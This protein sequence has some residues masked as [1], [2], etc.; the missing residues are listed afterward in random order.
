MDEKILIE[1]AKK[2]DKKAFEALIIPYERRLFQSAL[3]LM[4]NK[5][6]AE[7]VTQET[8]LIIYKKLYQFRGESKFYTWASRILINMCNKFRWKRKR[9]FD[10]YGKY[11]GN[12]FRYNKEIIKE[13]KQKHGNLHIVAKVLEKLENIYREVLY[14]L[15]FEGLSYEEIADVLRCSIGTIKSRIF[16]AKKKFKEIYESE[17]FDDEKALIK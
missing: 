16:N 12:E 7:D 15:Y 14:Y 4:S 8:L 1:N 13:W 2:G 17:Q 11:S 9:R 6:D 5:P 10:V 3:V